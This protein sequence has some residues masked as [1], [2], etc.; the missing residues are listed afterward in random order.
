[1]ST[2]AVPEIAQTLGLAEDDL[3]QEALRSLIKEKRRQVMEERLEILARYG[4]VSLDDLERK[5]ASGEVLEHPAWEDLIMA[6][7]LTAHLVTFNEH[8]KRLQPAG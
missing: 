4:A 6:E 7:N 1:M 2:I 3:I 8:L 5:I